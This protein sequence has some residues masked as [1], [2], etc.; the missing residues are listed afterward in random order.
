MAMQPYD[1]LPLGMAMLMSQNPEALDLYENLTPEERRSMM[2]R[3]EKDRLS[4]QRIPLLWD[5]VRNDDIEDK[6]R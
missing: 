3:M 6:T 1:F 4:A 2:K 5:S